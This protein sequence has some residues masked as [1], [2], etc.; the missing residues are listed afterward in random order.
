MLGESP[1]T[2][3]GFLRPA[4]ILAPNSTTKAQ[5]LSPSTPLSFGAQLPA[6]PQR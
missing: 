2:A 3:N 5:K 4:A 6:E 1:L